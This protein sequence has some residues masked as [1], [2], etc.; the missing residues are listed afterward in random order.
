MPNDIITFF[1]HSINN[2]VLLMWEENFKFSIIIRE[3]GV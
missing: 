1:H 3:N 2:F